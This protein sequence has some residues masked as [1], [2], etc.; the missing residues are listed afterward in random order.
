LNNDKLRKISPDIT[1]EKV[2]Y[3]LGFGLIGMMLI[4]TGFPMLLIIILCIFSYFL[5]KTVADKPSNSIKEIFEFYLQA[6]EILRNDE[7]KWYGF[8]IQDAIWRGEK[9]LQMMP[10]PP[11]LVNYALGSLYHKIGNHKSAVYHLSY[12]VENQES[13]EK[14]R[15]I[16]SPE[17]RNYV[18]LLRKI[19]QNP[20]EAPLMSAATRSLERARRNRATAILEESRKEVWALEEKN[21]QQL[22][23]KTED[24]SI[25][26]TIEESVLVEKETP[27]PVQSQSVTEIIE[28]AT[29]TVEEVIKEKP[30]RK[31]KTEPF[32]NHTPIS[33]VLRDLYDK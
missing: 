4:F 12:I 32:K 25:L 5:W 21:Q 24:K 8:E 26:Q 18:Q 17:L 29:K 10:D 16:A 15:S 20:A 9:I 7:R 23:A 27:Q 28:N 1:K 3:A 13:N 11:P 19:E 31:K 22:E 2:Q 33:E 6:N 14:N 30:K